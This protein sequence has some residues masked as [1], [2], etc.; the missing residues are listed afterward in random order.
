[1]GL[2]APRIE[3]VWAEQINTLVELATWAPLN[4]YA[5][6]RRATERALLPVARICGTSAL[7]GTHAALCPNRAWMAHA[8][9]C[10]GRPRS[11]IPNSCGSTA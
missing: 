11:A 2:L 10:C 6:A 1:M 4:D 7:G 8:K 5:E 9:R 3:N